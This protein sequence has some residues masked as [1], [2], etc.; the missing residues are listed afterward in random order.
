MPQALK[1]LS[2][3]VL[4]INFSVP[5]FGGVSSQATSCASK[6]VWTESAL[7]NT[8]SLLNIV[9]KLKDNPKCAAFKEEEVLRR[10]KEADETLNIENLGQTRSERIVQLPRE[11]DSLVNTAAEPKLRNSIVKLLANRT[12]E[13]A[14]QAVE[15]SSTVQIP[16]AL[17]FKVQMLTTLG[18]RAQR[19]ASVGA[20]ILDTVFSTSNDLDE[21]LM[22]TDAGLSLVSSAIHLAGSFVSSGQGVSSRFAGSVGRLLQM[23]RDQIG[24]AHV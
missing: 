14:A 5:A 13:S 19:V 22:G 1:A 21:C 15:L 7:E 4:F 20:T 16:S 11:I 2:T 18:Q 6:G 10:L 23:V 8:R 3:L 9:Q 17:S 24:R 12:L